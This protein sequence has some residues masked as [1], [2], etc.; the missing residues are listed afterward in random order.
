[1]FSDIPSAN[2]KKIEL[3]EKDIGK[4]TLNTL[5]RQA[6]N[7]INATDNTI[8][9]ISA[10]AN[11][12]SQVEHAV[13]N[14]HGQLIGKNKDIIDALIKVIPNSAHHAACHKESNHTPPAQLLQELQEREYLTLTPEQY[15]SLIGT[16][17]IIKKSLNFY[18]GITTKPVIRNIAKKTPKEIRCTATH[19][20]HA[21]RVLQDPAPPQ[22]SASLNGLLQN[23]R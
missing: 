15:I 21:K 23:N 1:M 14:G 17:N 9:N 2:R 16:Y 18:L 11:F 19:M 8:D 10:E 4:I 22:G 5:S 12:V 13:K 6:I 3:T 7:V 20:R